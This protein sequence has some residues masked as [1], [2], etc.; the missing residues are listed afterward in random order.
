MVVF[1]SKLRK[2]ILAVSGDID[3]GEAFVLFVVLF[4]ALE[5]EMKGTAFAFREEI[6]EVV[7]VRMEGA[8]EGAV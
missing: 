6:V 5:E 7:N 2:L 1:N 8:T 3:I 4:E